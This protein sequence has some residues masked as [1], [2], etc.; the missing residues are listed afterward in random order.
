M[1]KTDIYLK[2][3]LI[4]QILKEGKFI[5]GPFANLVLIF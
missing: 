4:I 1:K 2:N 3:F 5:S